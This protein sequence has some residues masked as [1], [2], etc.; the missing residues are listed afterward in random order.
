VIRAK[1]RLKRGGYVADLMVS[2]NAELGIHQ[3]SEIVPV[4]DTVQVGP[5]PAEIRNHT[6]YAGGVS[7][8]AKDAAAAK[9]LLDLLAG[10]A[11]AATLRKKG[12]D[13]PIS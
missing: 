2:R 9:A 12:M 7:A 13:R 8:T 10:P 6:T 4:K 11:G 5:L 3:I 1:A